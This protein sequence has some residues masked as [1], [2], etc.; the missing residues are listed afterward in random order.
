MKCLT[1]KEEV[2]E[3]SHYALSQNVCPFCGKSI[4]SDA[5]HYFRMSLVKIME[6]HGIKEQAQ[7]NDVTND[8]INLLEGP[9][10]EEAKEQG[11]ELA[12]VPSTNVVIPQGDG[13]V[14]VGA[15]LVSV[16]TQGGIIQVPVNDKFLNRKPPKPVGLKTSSGSS[17]MSASPIMSAPSE[18][19]D[20]S[21]MEDEVGAPTPEEAAEIQAMVD[22]GEII[23]TSLH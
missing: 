11:I 10:P 15:G 14:N 1:C 7:I 13:T 5:D 3:K 20:L 21:N 23:F 2:S 12:P 17:S 4:L 9:S 22:R 6:K 18:S 16:A 8:I 19:M